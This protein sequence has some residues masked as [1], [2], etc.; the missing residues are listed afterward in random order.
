KRGF[1]VL[2]LDSGRMEMFAVPDGHPPENRFND[3]KCDPAGRFWAGTM[4]MTGPREGKGS[5]FC[6]FPDRSVKRMLDGVTTSNGIAWSLDRKTMYYIDTPTLTVWAFDYD[7]RTAAISNRRPVASAPK[8]MGYPD[9]MTIDAE[10]MLWVAYWQGAKVARWDPKSGRLLQTIKVPADLT[11]SCAF[12]GPGMD[13]L[14]ITTART[15]L[16]PETL[17]S[18]PHAGGIFAVRPGVAGIEAF[19]FAG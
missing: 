10:G 13:V 18:Q 11:T 4:A 16:K 1:A 2:D 17:A 9:G 6:L 14:Y 12:G 15:G 8:E 19:E 3:G 7:E 5:L